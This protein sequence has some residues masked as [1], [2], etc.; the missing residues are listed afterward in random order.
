MKDN[1]L[2]VIHHIPQNRP[3]LENIESGLALFITDIAERGLKEEQYGHFVITSSD[4]SRYYAFWRG[5]QNRLFVAVSELFLF[6]ATRDILD[7]L[8]YEDQNGLYVTLLGLC[9]SPIF[10]ISGVS[11]NLRLATGTV[12][13][14]YST[15]EQTEDPDMS[16]VIT[17]VLT[18]HMLVSAWESL[19]LERKVLVTSSNINLIPLCC[20]YLRRL[21]LPLAVVN[22]YVPFLTK[23]LVKTVEAPFPYLVGAC[24]NT[25]LEACVDLSETV[26]VDLDRREVSIPNYVDEK[27]PEAPTAL[28]NRYVTAN[29]IEMIMIEL[30]FITE[31]I[32]YTLYIIHYNIIY[33]H[34]DL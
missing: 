7:N 32:H 5:F 9:E 34:L 25:V 27:V 33:I 10:P 17:S 19:I 28:M 24:S 21:V 29:G 4:G 2:K 31:V 11:Y 12:K 26:V 22:T 30:H 1:D 13:L 20:E 16:T 18:P 6:T 15:I 14:A 3:Q 8:L 23:Q